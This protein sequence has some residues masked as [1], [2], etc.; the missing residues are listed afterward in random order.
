MACH[1]SVRAGRRLKAGRDERAAAR[2]GSDAQFRPVQS[3]PA[4][5]RRIEARPTSNG[6]SGGA[7]CC[8]LMRHRLS[9]S[10][11]G[12]NRASMMSFRKQAS[13]DVHAG[14]ASWIAGSMPCAMSRRKDH[15]SKGPQKD[16]FRIVVRAPLEF[17]EPLRRR[18]ARLRR[19][20]DHD[21]RVAAAASRPR[22]PTRAPSR[23]G[24]GRRADR[25]RR[26]KTA[27]S[28]ARGRAWSRR[29]GKCARRRR[30]RARRH[31][32][33]AA[34][35]PPRRR[36]RTAR[37]P[38]RARRASMPER[39]GAG[40]KIEHARAGDRIA[41][42]VDQNIEQRLAQPVG[43]RPDRLRFRRGERA[44][45][46]SSADDCASRAGPPGRGRAA[47]IRPRVLAF[48]PIS[49]LHGEHGR[50]AFFAVIPDAA[51]RRSGFA[52]LLRICFWSPRF[53]L[54]PA[55]E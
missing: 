49:A 7:N 11:P 13:P 36:R 25:G 19:F 44:A 29:G 22:A 35:A 42:G 48:A 46:Q 33:A 21:Q 26:A 14:T 30:G 27:P 47:A 5:L 53:G 17:L 16:E 1:G 40:E 24:L 38:R 50:A 41:V 34:R 23:Q 39:A 20:L 31:S 15:W 51:K 4:D 52:C 54:R 43:G 32:R 3:R 10:C 45:A 18:E 9:V 2:D 28:D 8:R 37:K 12:L 55:P 6:C